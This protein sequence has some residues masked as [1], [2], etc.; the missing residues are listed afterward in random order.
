MAMHDPRFPRS[1]PETARS[2]PA[3]DRTDED[4]R[5]VPDEG[6][7]APDVRPCELRGRCYE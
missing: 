2:A 3:A 7:P 5:A 6:T 1:G 4:R